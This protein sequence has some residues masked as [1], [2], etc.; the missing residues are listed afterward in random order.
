MK[1]FTFTLLAFLLFS[2][3]LF[4][5]EVKFE[6]YKKDFEKKFDTG[7]GGKVRMYYRISGEPVTAPARIEIY[8]KC[9]GEKEE[10]LI[11]TIRICHLKKYTYE[12]SVHLLTLAY[13][14]GRVDESSTGQ[15]DA[16]D[17]R[18]LKLPNLCV[19]SGKGMKANVPLENPE[20]KA[21]SKSP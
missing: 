5:D 17:E 7:N 6:G 8:V 19:K 18:E 3:P 11:E 2:M 16:E 10:T 12:K 20:P 21:D 4:A 15:C 1:A 9:K 14:F 13:V